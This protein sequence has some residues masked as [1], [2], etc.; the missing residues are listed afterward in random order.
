[1]N[2]MLRRFALIPLLLAAAF[3][4]VIL[5]LRADEP[6]RPVA[7]DLKVASTNQLA[8]RPDDGEIAYVT[9]RALEQGHYRQHRL[10]D[11]YS[12]KFFDRYIEALDPQRLHFTQLDLNEFASYR[13]NLDNLT[14]TRPRAA[15]TTPAYRIFNR[16]RERL[17]QRVTYALDLLQNE[18]FVFDTDEQITVNRRDEPHPADLAA[19][20]QLW[21]QRLRSE[22][23]GEKI[24]KY[25]ANAI[26]SPRKPTL[27][28]PNWMKKR[29]PRSPSR[30]KSRKP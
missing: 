13:T 7:A 15:N 20:R 26:P 19:A 10:N 24:A 25:A 8:P 1:L 3:I 11:D 18:K 6:A 16:F 17:E 9:A 30:K 14:L 23:L 29:S 5:A 2:F 28:R 4:P 12:E 21:R 22:Y 27:R